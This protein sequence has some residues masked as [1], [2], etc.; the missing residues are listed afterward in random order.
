MQ[1]IRRLL[2][3]ADSEGLKA[4]LA[5]LGPETI[6]LGDCENLPMDG[7]SR[8]PTL[9]ILM[10]DP[11]FDF[12]SEFTTDMLYFSSVKM[13]QL[14]FNHPRCRQLIEKHGSFGNM[15]TARYS[16][17]TAKLLG[18][19]ARYSHAD[20]IYKGW[21]RRTNMKVAFALY[22][23]LVRWSRKVVERYYRPG[24]RGYLR[25]KASYQSSPVIMSSTL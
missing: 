19:V 20:H 8:R 11:R 15:F 12:N 17:A 14:I 4:H 13:R 7:P 10:D 25:A 5:S 1:S 9:K 6:C 22:P 2:L 24:G 21:K 3:N 23:Q 16:H 18:A